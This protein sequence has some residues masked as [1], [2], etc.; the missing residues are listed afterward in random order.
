MDRAKKYGRA[1]IAPKNFPNNKAGK[2]AFFK[3]LVEGGFKDSFESAWN[4]YP[5]ATKESTKSKG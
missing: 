4:K 2:Q 3:L 5:K 1:I